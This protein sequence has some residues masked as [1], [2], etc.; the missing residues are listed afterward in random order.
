MTEGQVTDH[1]SRE[2][3]KLPL[4]YTR[5][6]NRQKGLTQLTQIKIKF[7]LFHMQEAEAALTAGPENRGVKLHSKQFDYLLG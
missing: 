1:W 7:N 3:L 5:G 6:V 4:V 2:G